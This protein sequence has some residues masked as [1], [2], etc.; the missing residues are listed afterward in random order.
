MVLILMRIAGFVNCALK[1][2]ESV[3]RQSLPF[4]SFFNTCVPCIPLLRERRVRFSSSTS[5][6]VIFMTSEKD[7]LSAPLKHLSTRA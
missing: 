3:S 1:R 5:M 4:G 7:S 2:K 6:P